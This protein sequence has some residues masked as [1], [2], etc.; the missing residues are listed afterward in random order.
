MNWPLIHIGINHIPIILTM[1]GG[2][3]VIVALLRHRRAVW[4]YAAVTLTLAGLSVY[5]AYQA[6]EWTE[7]V[8]E[9]YPGVSHDLIEEH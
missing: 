6:R 9:K 3:A 8:V 7:D 1:L 4:L 2:G 5:S